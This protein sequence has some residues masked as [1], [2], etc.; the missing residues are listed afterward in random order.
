MKLLEKLREL[1]FVFRNYVRHEKILRQKLR[2]LFNRKK[3]QIVFK[4][5]IIYKLRFIV[6][7]L[8]NRYDTGTKY[9][10]ELN[11]EFSCYISF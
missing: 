4:S 8:K 10:I 2:P 5:V 3:M 1:K 11:S 9:F 6:K 7:V